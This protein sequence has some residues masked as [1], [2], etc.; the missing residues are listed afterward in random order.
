M[1]T[2]HSSLKTNVNWTH[3]CQFDYNNLPSLI[4]VYKKKKHHILSMAFLW[5]PYDC[6]IKSNGLQ[7]TH[8]GNLVLKIFFTKGKFVP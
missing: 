7:R 3:F 2:S 6:Y 5:S 4:K 8:D 1:E